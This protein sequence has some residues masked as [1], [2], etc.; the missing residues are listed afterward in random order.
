MACGTEIRENNPTRFDMWEYMTASID[1]KVQYRV[2]ENGLEVDYEIEYHR[3]YN[4]RYERDGKDGIVTLSLQSSTISMIEPLQ[5]VTIDRYL[6][7]GDRDIFRGDLI[8]TCSLEQFYR[9]YETKGIMFHDVLKVDCTSVSGVKQEYY[10]GYNEGLVAIYK[11]DG[12]TEIELI[13]V[14]ESLI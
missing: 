14:N 8:Q 4:G 2:Y 1:Y 7:L 5:D 10:Y 12:A 11:D 6:H 13:K 3:M 9:N